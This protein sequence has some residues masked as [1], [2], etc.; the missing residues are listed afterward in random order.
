[1]FE[2]NM[3]ANFS[4]NGTDENA[5]QILLREPEGKIHLGR[6]KGRGKDYNML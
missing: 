3:G 2:G 1:M 4:T 6:P 5:N